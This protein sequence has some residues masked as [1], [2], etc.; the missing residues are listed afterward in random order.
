MRC[1]SRCSSS[2]PKPCLP[3]SQQKKKHINIRFAPRPTYAW[4]PARQWNIVFVATGLST[5]FDFARVPS[6]QKLRLCIFARQRY[7]AKASSCLSEY[8]QSC[9]TKSKNCIYC[10]CI[11]DP[12]PSLICSTE[13][14]WFSH[15]RCNSMR[16]PCNAD[17]QGPQTHDTA[18]YNGT[19]FF[20][21]S[22]ASHLPW[23]CGLCS[24]VHSQQLSTIH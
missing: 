3:I 10:Q 6:F 17:S 15:A 16:T 22:L 5:L 11:Q 20:P 24:V 12:A 4:T 7:H 14:R 18:Q 2:S 9:H 21:L 23:Q 13:D 19:C 1:S 8:R